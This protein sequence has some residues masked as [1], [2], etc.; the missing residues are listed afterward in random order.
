[1]L[2]KVTGL[3]LTM[4]ISAKSNCTFPWA[5]EAIERVYN[6]TTLVEAIAVTAGFITDII[7][8]LNRLNDRDQ[9]AE[10]LPFIERI[11]KEADSL[12]PEYG[13]IFWTAAKEILE[14]YGGLPGKE[15]WEVELESTRRLAPVLDPTKD[16]LE[17]VWILLGN[18]IAYLQGWTEG[19]AE[20][21]REASMEYE[22]M[23]I[24]DWPDESPEYTPLGGQ[25][26]Y[27][28]AGVE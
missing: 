5:E 10:Y 22:L 11:L 16:R 24:R 20:G 12:E 25:D 19:E 26:E 21:I 23:Q 13:W 3:P 8:E 17:E 9:D 2:G 14:I 15:A 7:D 27:Q 6:S 18:V 1:M 28:N 4:S